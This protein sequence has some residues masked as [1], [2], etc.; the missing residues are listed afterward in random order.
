MT[1]I[2]RFGGAINLSLHFHAVF[3]E[4]VYLDRR[5]QGLKP[6]FVKAAPPSDADIARVLQKINRTCPFSPRNVRLG[7]LSPH[8][9]AWA[10]GPPQPSQVALPEA[11]APGHP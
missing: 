7:R 11:V 10:Q 9:R 4:G 8:R 2:Q 6:R 3:L 5:D 1:F